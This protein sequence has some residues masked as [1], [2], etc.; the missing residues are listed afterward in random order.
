MPASQASVMKVLKDI[1]QELCVVLPI[2]R[3]II[4]IIKV[5]YGICENLGFSAN[6]FPHSQRDAVMS[7]AENV[8]GGT[9][10]SFSLYCQ[11]CKAI[12]RNCKKTSW[13]KEKL[14]FHTKIFFKLEVPF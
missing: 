5:L 2:S 7:S 12:T 11:F 14:L 9:E 3:H 10:S 1:L 6:L 13:T 8:Q 4:R